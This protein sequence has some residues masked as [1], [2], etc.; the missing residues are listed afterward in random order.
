M[1]F[2]AKLPPRRRRPRLWIVDITFRPA[3]D[4]SYRTRQLRIGSHKSSVVQRRFDPH[5]YLH[6]EVIRRASIPCPLQ[7]NCVARVLHGRD[8]DEVLVSHNTRR[9]IE[10][11]PARTWNVSLDPSVGVTTSNLM[12]VFVLL[13]GQMQVTR[14]KPRRNSARA[15][16]RH[17]QHREVAATAAP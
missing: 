7:R 12:L 15:Q 16:R 11:D 10:V 3:A 13:F 14:N 8:A 2:L 17:H 1:K 6:G 4:K 9:R 5:R